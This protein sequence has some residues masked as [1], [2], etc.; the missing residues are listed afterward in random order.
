[1]S[2]RIG[3]DVVIHTDTCAVTHKIGAFYLFFLSYMQIETEQSY[4]FILL[5][6]LFGLMMIK[7]PAGFA[8]IGISLFFLYKKISGD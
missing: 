1:L 5:L 7:I 2:A 3:H 6:F 4:S 8:L